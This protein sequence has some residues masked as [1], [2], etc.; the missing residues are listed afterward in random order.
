[1][2]TVNQLI[3]K[4]R[5]KVKKK[6]LAPALRGCPREGVFALRSRLLLPKA[7][8]GFKEGSPGEID[9]WPGSI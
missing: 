8:L 1:M 5:S 3:R 2:P 4:P 9:Y 7:K 6:N